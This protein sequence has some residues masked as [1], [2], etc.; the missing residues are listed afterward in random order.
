MALEK[1][2]DR[3]EYE[4]YGLSEEEIEIVEGTSR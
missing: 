2:I 4:V 1:E 3:S